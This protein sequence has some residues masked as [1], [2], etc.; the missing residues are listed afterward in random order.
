MEVATGRYQSLGILGIENP[1]GIAY[2]GVNNILYWSDVELRKL[3]RS[4]ID[5]RDV[6]EVYNLDA[7]KKME[8]FIR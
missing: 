3:M 4:N 7:G 2:D 8:G 1:I 6:R 5:G